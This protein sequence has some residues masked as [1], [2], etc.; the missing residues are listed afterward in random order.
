MPLAPSY[1]QIH[2]KARDL[3]ELGH[4]VS[5]IAAAVAR[6]ETWVNA[7]A[8]KCGWQRPA[9]TCAHC[10]VAVPG[11]TR[12]NRAQARVCE[13]CTK[14]RHREKRA[15]FRQDKA[16]VQEERRRAAERAGKTYRTR[17][18]HRAHVA[19]A[20]RGRERSAASEVGRYRHYGEM[21]M[22][23]AGLLLAIRDTLT[24]LLSVRCDEVGITRETAHYRLRYQNDPAFRAKEK[25]K[26]AGR[27]A[28]R[29]AT[30]E[31]DGTLTTEVVRRLFAMTSVCAYCDKLMQSREKTLDHMHPVS[32]GGVHGISNVTVCCASCNARKKDLLFH[33]W[34]A[35]LPRHIA[36]RF[37]TRRAA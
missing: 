35:R 11:G 8:K 33:K 20:L 10:R 34:V 17:E 31:R 32:M 23:R 19:D 9:P 4:T 13:S 6:S 12:R 15:R 2:D 30:M 18:E 14:A 24:A 25:A 7:T 3:F 28:K 16:R 21:P 1:R 22:T 27:K 5:S 26:T 37:E 29:H 36:A